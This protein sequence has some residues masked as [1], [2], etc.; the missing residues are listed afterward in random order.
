MF[1]THWVE[2]CVRKRTSIH[3]LCWWS[4]DSPV[5]GLACAGV[6]A[7]V[8]STGEFILTAVL[9]ASTPSPIEAIGGSAMG[10][11]MSDLRRDQTI[12][13]GT[14]RKTH[15]L[16]K[17]TSSWGE[18]RL[19]QTRVKLNTNPFYRYPPSADIPLA[20][21]NFE[22]STSI[23]CSCHHAVE[24]R[25]W[26]SLVHRLLFPST[27]TSRSQTA[28]NRHPLVN[29][30]SVAT[31]GCIFTEDIAV[32]TSRAFWGSLTSFSKSHNSFCN[33]FHGTFLKAKSYSSVNTLALFVSDFLENR[34]L[35]VPDSHSDPGVRSFQPDRRNQRLIE[36]LSILERSHM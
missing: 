10:V 26:R 9:A 20:L 8:I 19:R 22:S 27:L 6:T 16:M 33:S 1:Y 34:P 32:R 29:H 35:Q 17:L 21:I 4:D 15:P 5:Y 14:T 31:R 23:Q 28:S 36:S 30:W 2:M 18:G 11:L 13:A 7:E 25:W 24:N 3:D 12:L